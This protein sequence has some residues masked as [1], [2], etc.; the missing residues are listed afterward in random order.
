MAGANHNASMYFRNRFGSRLSSLQSRRIV[1]HIRFADMAPPVVHPWMELSGRW[2]EAAALVEMARPAVTPE[3]REQLRDV[4]LDRTVS[5]L[6]SL[7]QHVGI[8]VQP[9]GKSW[10][11]GARCRSD[12]LRR[13]L[14]EVCGGRKRVGARM[15]QR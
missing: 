2:I 5:T 13:R 11:G 10:L 1:P 12:G 7:G 3:R 6:A 14:E 15:R 9:G 8:V 4:T